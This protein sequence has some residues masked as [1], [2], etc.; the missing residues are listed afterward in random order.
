M[1][2]NTMTTTQALTTTGRTGRPRQELILPSA[3][4]GSML[5]EL[6]R[7]ALSD[8]AKR[9]YGRDL[10]D[11]E[12]WRAGRALTKTLVEE[13]AQDLLDQGRAVSGVNRAL[14]AIRWWSRRVADLAWE[15]ANLDDD[16]RR[17]TADNAL[18]VAGVKAIKGDDTTT[19]RAITAGEIGALLMT[20]ANDT[21]AAG[22]R[23]AAIVAMLYS[24]GI[25]RQELAG[26]Q[27]TDLTPGDDGGL[28]AIVRK[29]KGRKTRQAYIYN[30]ALG[31]LE[32]WL[33]LRGDAP[34]AIFCN[35][36]RSGAVQPGT[37]L[38]G[39]AIDAIVKQRC[40]QAGVK[41]VST[42]DF[43]RTFASTLLDQGVDLV[44]VSKLMGHANVNTTARYDRRDV[45]A[46]KRAVQALHVPYRTRA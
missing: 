16:G 23:D 12:H 21:S 35:V 33:Q 44:V 38:S 37:R 2:Q 3:T 6:D 10:V 9:A 32:S 27:L 22:T 41:D 36:H 34:G 5:Q 18:R 20:C 45:T 17:R 1:E 4:A 39:V 13:Y 43:R 11:F 19:G 8:N 42:H 30:G 26:L 29:G 7:A 25:R 28:V 14:S 24:T 15:D 40:A 31:A 46:R